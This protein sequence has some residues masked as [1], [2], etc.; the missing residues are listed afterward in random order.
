M[1]Q[2]GGK[3]KKS[4]MISCGIV[5]QNRK[6]RFHYAIQ[7]TVEAGLVLLGPEVKSLRLGRATITEAFAAE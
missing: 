7:E 4:T 1:S 3:T 2:K 5:A 6:A